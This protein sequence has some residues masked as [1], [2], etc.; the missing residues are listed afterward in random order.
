MN[1]HPDTC[2][3]RG[4]GR[5]DTTGAGRHARPL[6]LLAAA[7]VAAAIPGCTPTPEDAWDRL[8]RTGELRIGYAVE[9]PYA[10]L[11]RNGEVTGESPELARAIC[12]RLGV[13]RTQWRLTEFDN[14][15]DGLEAGRFDLI[16]AGM[17]IT[18]ERQRRIDFSHPTFRVRPALLVPRGNPGHLPFS[19]DGVA[20]HPS[21]RIAVV[22]GSVEE[23]LFLQL[24][25]PPERLIQVP[26]AQAGRAMVLAHSADALALSSP[27]VRW[28][29]NAPP[30]DLLECLVMQ[31]SVAGAAAHPG[32]AGSGGFG[33]R[34]RDHR[35]REAWNR[36]LAAI[37]NSREHQALVAPFGFT[38]DELPAPPPASQSPPPSP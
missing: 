6:A 21:C 1:P 12:L 33:F 5:T 2:S 11:H 3:N 13:H 15:I 29:A 18:P 19:Y 24:A 14:L 31:P 10:F 35:L 25:L 17:F 4:S 8:R 32:D 30:G 34:K 26:D 20:Q 9:A 28:M 16:A 36:E 23:Q 38:P 22:A 37:L 7:V 27:A